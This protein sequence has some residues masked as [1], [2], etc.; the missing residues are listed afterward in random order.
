MRTLI[1]ASALILLANPAWAGDCEAPYTIDDLLGDLVGVEQFVREGDDAAAKIASDRL[2]AGLPCLNELLPTMIVGRSFRAVAAGKIVG[3]DE[4]GGAA[5]FKTAVGVEQSF[6]YGLEDI[7]ELLPKGGI[8]RFECEDVRERCRYGVSREVFQV[9]S[10][11]NCF[12]HR[13]WV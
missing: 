8:E 13:V 5:W 2:E 9:S 3:G 11:S 1:A 4:V 6:E 7:S 12:A 10:N